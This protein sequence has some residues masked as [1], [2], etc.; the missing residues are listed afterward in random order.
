LLA[1]PTS[2]Q[3]DAQ[4]VV[5]LI[6]YLSVYRPERVTITTT[7]DLENWTPERHKQYVGLIYHALRYLPY[8]VN[9]YD[10]TVIL[11]R[12][13]GNHLVPAHL[14]SGLLDQPTKQE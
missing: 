14:R 5:A 9:V 1:T 7:D 11:E 6:N 12:D 4:L 2:A 3:A 10:E 13:N 8:N